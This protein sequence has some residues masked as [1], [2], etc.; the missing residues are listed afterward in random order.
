MHHWTHLVLGTRGKVAV[1]ALG[2]RRST[3]VHDIVAALGATRRAVAVVRIVF[4]AE[5]M[6]DLVSERDLRYG[7]G[8]TGLI[9][10]N[11]DNTTVQAFGHALQSLSALADATYATGELGDPSEA[12]R[13]VRKVS[14]RERIGET[15][16]GEV[17][18]RD[19]V[20]EGGHVQI[21]FA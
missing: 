15:V 9:V 17:V 20:E 8:N 3:P 7:L 16:V 14:G 4:G 18:Q 21:E 13:S 6:A 2:T 19:V 10:D 12:E 11:S 1:I 5:V